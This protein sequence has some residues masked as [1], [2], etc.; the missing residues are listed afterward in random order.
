MRHCFVCTPLVPSLLLCR[1]SEYVTTSTD[2]SVRI[3]DAATHQQLFQLT[4][5]ST[6]TVN[7]STAA[8]C[9][10]SCAALNPV[11]AQLAVG[12]REGL[13]RL[14]DVASSQM[15]Q[16]CLEGGMYYVLWFECWSPAV[17]TGPGQR[18]WESLGGCLG[19]ARHVPFGVGRDRE[20]PSCSTGDIPCRSQ[21][22]PSPVVPQKQ[23]AG[24]SWLSP[25]QQHSVKPT[26]PA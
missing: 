14:F 3:W 1:R 26:P 12:Y 21:T 16:V 8:A 7:G 6:A 20:F 4:A 10:P 22:P 19:P 24:L 5:G 25:S 9:R 13:V 17:I 11:A 2:G 23:G 15:L 18:C